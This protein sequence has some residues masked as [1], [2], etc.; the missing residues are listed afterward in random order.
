MTLSAYY[1]EQR[2]MIQRRVFSNIPSPIFQ[3]ETYDNLDFG[4]VKGFSFTYDR[5]RVG[6]IKLTATYTLQFADGSGSDANSSGGL[7]TRGPIRNLIPL[8]YDERHRITS[9]IDYR[10]GSGKK[11]DGPRIGGVDIFAN[12]G[13]NFI[14]NAVSG[15]PYTKRRTVQ[16]FGGVG[17]EGAINGARL[18]WNATIDARLDKSFNLNTGGEG[19]RPLYFNVYLRVQNLLDT[20]NVYGVYSATGSE[21]DDGYLISSFGQDRISQVSANGQSEEVF[22]AQYNYRL[23]QPGFYSLARRIYLGATVNF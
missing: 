21:E 23:L 4:T 9:T 2:D 7:N 14:V 19:G 22:L 8:S 20:K 11:Y 5:R 12:T 13:L 16:Q 3:Y 6:N 10:Y 17:F 1:R 15:R 18:P